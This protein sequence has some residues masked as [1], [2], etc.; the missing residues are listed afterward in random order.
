MNDSN[1]STQ[2]AAN[3]DAAAKL[4]REIARHILDVEGGP[5]VRIAMKGGKWPD[6]ETDLGGLCHSALE[7]RIHEV[8]AKYVDKTGEGCPGPAT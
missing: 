2:D 1:S 4:A 8:L 7:Q 6:K 3:L 5:A